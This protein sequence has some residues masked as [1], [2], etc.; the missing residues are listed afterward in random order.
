M[1]NDERIYFR[2]GLIGYPLE[3][4]F[5]PILHER[6]L[7]SLGLDG[8]YHLYTFPP[9]PEGEQQVRGICE[10]VR[11][12]TVTGL[13]V[14]IPHKQTVCKF[15]DVLSPVAQSTKAVNT[16]YRNRSGELVGDNTDVPGFMR[17]ISCLATQIIGTA[18]V[19]GAGG[20]ARAVV[21]GLCQAGWEVCVLARRAEQSTALVEEFNHLVGIQSKVSHIPMGNQIIEDLSRN[22]TLLVNTTPLGMH[23]NV[24]ASPW[25]SE[26]PLPPRAFVYDLI[27]N[28]Q[29]TQLLQRARE[30]GLRCANGSGML[31]AQ[32]AMSFSIWTGHEPPFEV[33]ER[34]FR[35]RYMLNEKG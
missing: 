2:L 10:Q 7:E 1:R 34:V 6:A 11:A 3:H 4:S 16:I 14:T 35:S 23:P 32:A 20:A 12:G 27:Y 19:L 21:Y 33:M 15:V 30:E 29:E 24:E 18:L 9:T 28:P 26:I 25:P 5:S 8:E 13:N 22:C 17:E 31:V